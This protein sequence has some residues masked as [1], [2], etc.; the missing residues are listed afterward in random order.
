MD[1]PQLRQI[2]LN[3]FQSLI[4]NHFLVLNFKALHSVGKLD[5]ARGIPGQCREEQ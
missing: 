5:N 1:G 4:N 2:F 3:N